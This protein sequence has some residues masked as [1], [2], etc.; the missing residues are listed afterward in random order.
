[1]TLEEYKKS[2]I[3]EAVTKGLDPNVE[4]KDSG[5]EW[6]GMIPEKWIVKKLKYVSKTRDKKVANNQ[7]LSYF[8]LENIVK[9]CEV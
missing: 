8:A 7:G 2:V 5:V 4:M 3:T 6:I 1:M 9:L